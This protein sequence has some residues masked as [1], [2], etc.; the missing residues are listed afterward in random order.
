MLLRCLFSLLLVS[1]VLHGQPS[2][3]DVVQDF[4]GTQ[5]LRNAVIA[6]DVRDV[7]TG[8]QLAGHNAE[9]ACIPAST[10]KLITTAAAMDLLGPDH[11]FR[12]WLV[13]NGPIEGGTL[14]GN[15]VIVGGG[16]P[17]LGSSLMEGVA[18]LDEVVQTWVDKVRA[19]GI[20]RIS[21]AV[22]G[23]GS[24]YTTDGAGRGWSWADLGNY[25][26][27]GTY[28]LNVNENAYYLSFSQRQREGA[29]PPI[30]DTEPKVP[31]LVFVNELTSG[32][33]GS[34]D[35][36]YI[37]GA[38]FNYRQY[39][40]GTI[41]VGTGRFR[42]RGSIPDPA[43]LAAQLLD[44]KLEASGVDV[45][46]PPASDQTVGSGPYGNGKV[47]DERRS[48]PLSE[49]VDRTNLTSNNLYAETLLREMNK[50]RGNTDLASTDIVIDWLES[51][52][53]KTEGVRL[54]DGS[55]L[56]A[57]NFFPPSAMTTLLV[58]RSGSDRWR[59]SIPLAGRTGSLR[60]VLRGTV[61]EGRVQGKSGTI[62][63]VRAYAG[64]VDRPDGRRLAYSIAVNNHTLRG[65]RLNELIYGLMRDLCTA[66]L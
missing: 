9:R 3:R 1:T 7:N 29:T 40:R 43:L 42:I 21:G 54:L 22:V 26:G 19:A 41:P 49:I 53:V 14:R 50:A 11:R 20:T 44:R 24:Y 13:A 56:S 66:S 4:A 15:L 36:A 65:S 47:L 61:A 35:R 38:P 60:R 28:G 52:G 12:T 58:D 27:A 10:Q 62:D 59:E 45:V 46:Q 57:R 17:T 16:D 30:L 5:E 34:G 37:F 55:G 23:D 63:A 33:R 2:V 6:V 64:Y 18:S 31:G 39:V 32:P 48:P 25:Y 51:R 8:R